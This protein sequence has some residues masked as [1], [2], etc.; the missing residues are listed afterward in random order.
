MKKLIE[1]WNSET[2][3]IARVLQWVSGVIG[4]CTAAVIALWGS[5]PD[6]FKQTIPDSVKSHVVYVSAI[7][8]LLP[9]ILQFSKKKSK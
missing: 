7:G 4:S 1:L 3:K 5:L 6:E 2:P 8:V 9:I